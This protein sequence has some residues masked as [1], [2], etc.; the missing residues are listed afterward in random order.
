MSG[1][2]G[3]AEDYLA[4]RRVLGFKLKRHARLL[5]S[6]VA[7][8]DEAGASFVTADLAL[9]WATQPAGSAT[10]WAERLSVVRGFARHLATIDARTQVPPIGLLKRPGPARRRAVPYLYSS[11]DI[12][13]LMNAARELRPLQAATYETL[14]GLLAI[15]GLRAG[16][17]IR[18]DRN[19][20]DDERSVLMVRDTKFGKSRLV[21]LHESTLAALRG[22][23]RRRD[24][25]C[26]QA[27]PGP[28]LFISTS[29]TRLLYKVV[30]PTF[31]RLCERAGLR[32]RS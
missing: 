12:V 30:Q 31:A 29:G 25:L 24:E 1:L 8:L 28:S 19:D 3:A 14:I 2:A 27:V 11:Q 5:P 4:I 17:A 23:L 26:P 13:A 15:G 18:L 7:F 6:F 20:L 21:P 16:E 22:Y 32:P 9:R 10:W